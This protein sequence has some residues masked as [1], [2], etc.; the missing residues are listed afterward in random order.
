[1]RDGDFQIG[2]HPSKNIEQKNNARRMQ[3][4]KEMLFW[5]N[6]KIGKLGLL[7]EKQG[8][9]PSTNEERSALRLIRKRFFS[10]IEGIGNILRI[11]SSCIAGICVFWLAQ[12]VLE[13][14]GIGVFRTS[15]DG[16]RSVIHLQPMACR[17][18][19]KLPSQRS[20]PLLLRISHA[21]NRISREKA[22]S[23]KNLAIVLHFPWSCVSNR[24]DATG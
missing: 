12:F 11:S 3:K 14:G 1:M 9:L 10:G 18:V 15:Q 21:I 23:R 7:L 20:P 4:S 13:I 2:S 22:M 6:S 17:I 16:T 19:C 5:Q 8:A 24:T